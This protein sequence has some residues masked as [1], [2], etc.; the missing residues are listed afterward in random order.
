[1]ITDNKKIIADKA[2]KDKLIGNNLPIT[3]KRLQELIDCADI[4]CYFGEDGEDI[5]FESIVEE[6]QHLRKENAG[7]IDRKDLLFEEVD[8]LKKLC[9]VD[10]W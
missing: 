1:M 4:V 8:R 5:D 9:E 7:L 10:D 6:L 2:L 3:P